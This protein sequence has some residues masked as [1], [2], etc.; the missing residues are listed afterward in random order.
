MYLK[1]E[2]RQHMYRA[3]ASNGCLSTLSMP[4]SISHSCHNVGMQ[5]CGSLRQAGPRA[6]PAMKANSFN[7]KG[8]GA[9]SP[10]QEGS[11]PGG[12]SAVNTN[13]G[14]PGATSVQS[15]FDNLK[16]LDLRSELCPSIRLASMQ[17]T[18]LDT[19]EFDHWLPLLA[20][21]HFGLLRFSGYQ[22]IIKM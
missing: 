5:N 17:A 13:L 22:S 11:W 18:V 14:G 12:K 16:S 19:D 3:N 10:E 8:V 9:Q 7:P 4:T 6:T 2:Q 21:K 15:C 20:I 1:R